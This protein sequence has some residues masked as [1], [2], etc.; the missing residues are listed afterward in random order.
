M[1]LF[2]FLVIKNDLFVC[3]F[4]YCYYYYFLFI[5]ST[6]AVSC[7]SHIVTMKMIIIITTTL[8]KN[9]INSK[10]KQINKEIYCYSQGCT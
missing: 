9:F 6:L 10:I 5:F 2:F 4:G 3:L 7:H 1:I 8:F